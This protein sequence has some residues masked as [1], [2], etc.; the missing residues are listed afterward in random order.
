MDTE[1]AAVANLV[2]QNFFSDVSLL[3]LIAICEYLK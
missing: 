1:T 2:W 3:G